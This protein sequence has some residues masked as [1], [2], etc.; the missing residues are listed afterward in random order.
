MDEIWKDIQGYEGLYKVSN[1]G[2]VK[3]LERTRNMNLPGRERGAPVP[4]RILVPQKKKAGYLG[5]TLSKDGRIKNFRIHC[6]VAQA[7]LPNPYN[8]PQVNH[9]N[10]IKWDNRF[11]NIEWATGSENQRHALMLGLRDMSHRRKNVFQYDM[12]RNF[13]RSW[14]GAVEVEQE[15]GMSQKYIASCCRGDEP[16]AYGFVWKYGSR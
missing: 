13:I 8:K 9:I 6:L 2:R 16:S 12:R 5:V 4:E 14:N 15:T 10:G 11:S 3:S 1:M 7:F